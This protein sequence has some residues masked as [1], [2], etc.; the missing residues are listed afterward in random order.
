MS[1]TAVLSQATRYGELDGEIVYNIATNFAALSRTLTT[2]QRADIAMICAQQILNGFPLTPEPYAYLYSDQ[3]AMP[4]ITNTDF[5]FLPAMTH[6]VY[7][8]LIRVGH[9]QIQSHLP[10]SRNSRTPGK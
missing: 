6:K 2:A 3:I 1:V 5:L 8:P 9:E 4:T 10:C 7:L